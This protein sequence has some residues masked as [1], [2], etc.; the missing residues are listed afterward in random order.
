M[1]FFQYFASNWDEIFELL[2]EH[3]ELT[4]IA[5]GFSLLIGIPLGIF[6]SYVKN[7]DKAVIG[8]ANVVQAIPSIALLGFMIPL[9]GVGT[10]PAV[11]A[12]VLYSLL[13]IVKNTYTGLSNIDKNTVDAAKAIGLKPWQ[14]L[15]KIKLP[16]ALPV[17]MAGVRVAS[18][19]AVGLMT[20]AA[21]IGAGGLGSLIFQGV[22]SVNNNQILSGAIPAC[23]L[24]LLIDGIL[25][26]VEKLIT[27]ITLLKG[28]K[29]HN[30]KI[31]KPQLAIVSIAIIGLI[32][33]VSG[34][35][36]YK[37][38]PDPSDLNA[39]KSSSAKT[40]RIA[41]KDFTEQRIL[42]Y[43][44]AYMIAENTDYKVDVSNIGLTGSN[45]V[46]SAL[47]SG[48]VDVYPDYVGTLYSSVLGQTYVP[49]TPMEEIYDYTQ[50]QL[51]LQYDMTMLE[52][53]PFNNT[54]G[55][56]VLQE[57]ATEYGLSKISD[58]KSLEDQ[59]E[60][61]FTFEFSERD[62]GLS[63][64]ENMYGLDIPGKNI[65]EFGGSN[66][67]YQALVNGDVDVIDVFTTDA[68]IEKFDVAVLEDDLS[69]FPPYNCVPVMTN[70]ALQEFPEVSKALD[71]LE[72]YLDNET[73][74]ALN[75]QVDVDQESP[76][77]VAAGFLDETFG[78]QLA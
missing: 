70:T 64:M 21:Y 28:N 60:F 73:M 78:Y 57:T 4:A 19:T 50:E 32:A 17:I 72:P 26:L 77:E 45:V 51:G 34:Y 66:P 76:K 67:R 41:S 9:F 71:L 44:Y 35:H 47:E 61:G 52:P 27:P 3:I 54:Y 46:F 36:I 63:G 38:I 33:L 23:L 65:Q 2:V 56:G 37:A 62:D 6:I 12:V 29:E 53:M 59:L 40:I 20:L 13:P 15:L 8:V 16:L 49:A 14:V 69:F 55:L 7:T 48:A 5:V 30:L 43:M 58:L 10:V 24:A 39:G 74:V 18:V 1:N 25:A 75:Y 42:G 11:A 22:N 68:L 31:R